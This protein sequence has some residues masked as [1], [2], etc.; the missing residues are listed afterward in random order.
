MERSRADRI[1][2]NWDSISRQAMPPGL[3]RRSAVTTGLPASTLSAAVVLVLAI[4]A[5]G[6]W[7]GLPRG[8]GQL[9]AEPSASPAEPSASPAEP[10]ASP[11]EPSASPA[12][13]SAS[14][15]EPSPSPAEPSPSAVEPSPSPAASWPSD[16]E[17][18]G[19]LA[20]IPP[21]D[22]TDLARNEGTLRITDTCV[23]LESTG[24]LWL[25]VWPA[26]LTTWSAESRTITFENYDGR[27]VSVGDGDH[28]VIGGGG[29]SEAESGISGEEWVRRAEW[30]A[31]PAPSC[32]LD[33]RF[34]VGV[35]G[36]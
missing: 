5:A 22:G 36:E 1:L 23:Y 6:I 19:P 11:A 3:P 4:A 9:G 29:D 35:V 7:L 20:V 34:S 13:P 31:E 17:A 25:L 12:E 16:A 2:A 18:W 27:V 32:S 24:E 26:D 14:P 33:P 28:V 10:S 15:A 30:V 8:E 21:Q